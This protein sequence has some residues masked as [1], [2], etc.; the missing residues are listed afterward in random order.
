M[1]LSAP[2]TNQP[3]IQAVVNTELAF[4][5]PPLIFQRVHSNIIYNCTA[6]ND[7]YSRHRV[8]IW[9]PLDRRIAEET[10]H[11]AGTTRVTERAR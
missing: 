1:N 10:C 4:L 2:F 11:P 3:V 6:L 8:P 9:A 5:D 7:G